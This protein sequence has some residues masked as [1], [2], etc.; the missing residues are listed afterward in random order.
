MVLC[1]DYVER[2]DARKGSDGDWR[3]NQINSSFNGGRNAVFILFIMA[4]AVS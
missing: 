4:Q 3:K 2:W 1:P